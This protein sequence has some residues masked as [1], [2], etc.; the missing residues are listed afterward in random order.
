MSSKHHILFI[1]PSLAGGGAE[2][3]AVNLLRH[4]DRGRFKL[5]LII[6]SA[7]DDRYL[8]DIPQDVEIFVLNK[9]R[10]RSAVVDIVKLIRKHKPNTVFSVQGHLSLFIILFRRFFSKKITMIAYEAS[11]VTSNLKNDLISIAL[12]FLY[13]YFYK[14]FDIVVCQS[15]VM[16]NDLINNFNLN[17]NKTIVIF[18]PVDADRICAL[19]SQSIPI[20]IH[21]PNLFNFV[22]VGR[23]SPEKG[24]D[25]LIEAISMLER[26]DVSL[27][28]VG[29][30]PLLESL[31]AQVKFLKL[32]SQV[33]FIGFLSN[34]FPLVKKADALILSSHFE[35]MP[36]VVL[37]ALACDTPVLATP[38]VGGVFDIAQH[39][40][41]VHLAKSISS[42][43]LA[44][45]I[46]E[47]ITNIGS[48]DISPDLTKFLIGPVT[49]KYENLFL[50]LEK[51]QKN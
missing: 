15:V 45:L 46:T 24:F 25:I 13:K 1:V 23:L 30:G 44:D 47:F 7:S 50:R 10:V 11:I 6:I 14:Y 9:K 35:G 39:T 34:P 42:S 29:E 33:N 38:A 41:S 40:G 26:S 16:Q 37:E 21:S 17:A 32:E 4:I 22:A 19:A 5:S 8:N 36:N 51:T 20:H 49:R 27:T 48:K 12:R 31:V 43:A 18:N 3:F 2:R 28:I